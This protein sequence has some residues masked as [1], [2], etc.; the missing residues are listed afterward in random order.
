MKRA[1]R[2][3]Q[4][5]QS[6]TEFAAVSTILFMLVFGIFEFGRAYYYYNTVMNTADEGARYGVTDQNVTCIQTIATISKT[7]AIGLTPSDVAVTCPDGSC[8]YGKRISVAVNYSFTAVAPFIPSFPMSSVA[9]MR[10]GR[11]YDSGGT[12]N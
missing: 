9:T 5:G 11:T 7:V 3:R 10:I 1:E 8:V 6:L 12:C 2:R 4:A